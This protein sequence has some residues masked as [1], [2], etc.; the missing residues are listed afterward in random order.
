MRSITPT[1][2]R[3]SYR[4]I[5]LWLIAGFALPMGAVNA[6]T[7][8]MVTLP[9]FAIDKTEVTIGAFKKFSDE[10]GFVTDAERSG[11]GLV[12]EVGWK[13]KSGWT[14]RSP[15]GL[16]ARDDEPAVH[17]TFDEASA[18]CRWAGKRLPTESEWVS[19]AYTEQRLSPPAPF[20]LS[21][22]HI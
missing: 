17:I 3:G 1:P 7:V 14:W 15:Y 22:I 18:Y 11:G 10:T 4:S 12:F 5:F 9:S 20:E 19:A 2:L 8:A 16:P 13:K 6:E 21:L